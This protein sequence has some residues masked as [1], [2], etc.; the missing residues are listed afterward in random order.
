MEI[1]VGSR[2]MM[3]IR[4]T[5]FVPRVW[6]TCVSRAESVLSVKMKMKMWSVWRK[7]RLWY[8]GSDQSKICGRSGRIEECEG[9]VKKGRRGCRGSLKKYDLWGR[10]SVEKVLS[11]FWRW[12]LTETDR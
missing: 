8:E 9:E 3:R 4:H 7:M 10:A 2:R 11:C 12:C 6:L 1:V 5:M